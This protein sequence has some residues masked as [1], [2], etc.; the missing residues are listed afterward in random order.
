L[1]FEAKDLWSLFYCLQEPQIKFVG[2]FIVLCLNQKQ[3]KGRISHRKFFMV[4]TPNASKA[5]K[6]IQIGFEL[7]K[8]C[9]YEV[10]WVI[11]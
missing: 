3:M 7:S 6:I 4:I 5:T 2:F 1:K 10:K 8:I 9:S 11:V